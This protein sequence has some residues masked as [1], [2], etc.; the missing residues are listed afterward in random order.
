MDKSVS[1]SDLAVEKDSSSSPQEKDQLATWEYA[2]TLGNF[3]LRC[4]API[5]VGVQ[6]EWGSGKTSLINMVESHLHQTNDK[7]DGDRVFTL[8][9]NTW[10]HSLLQTPESTLIS[11]IQ[12]IIDNLI[13]LDP[14]AKENNRRENFKKIMGNLARRATWMGLAAVGGAP[15]VNA[16]KASNEQ[17]ADEEPTKQNMIKELRDHL[18]NLSTSIKGQP[19][20]Y[21]RFVIFIDDLDRLEPPVAVAVLELL[22]NI[23]DIPHT[24]FVLAIDYQVVVKG[25]ASKFGDLNPDNEREFRSFFDKIIQVPFMM[26]MAHYSLEK[27]VADLLARINYFDSALDAEDPENKLLKDLTKVVKSTIG[28][29]PRSLKRLTNSLAL[30][31]LQRQKELDDKK[32]QLLFCLICFQIGFPNVFEILL[33]RPYFPDWTDEMAERF[34]RSKGKN[35][36]PKNFEDEIDAVSKGSE[37]FDAED[38][39]KA[40]QRALFRVI[41]GMDWQKTRVSETAEVLQ[42]IYEKFIKDN[43]DNKD[44]KD[45]EELMKEVLR[46]AGTTSVISWDTTAS[47]E[48][49]EQENGE[50]KIKYW[51]EFYEKVQGTPFSTGKAMRTAGHTSGWFGRKDQ[52][53][54]GRI[55]WAAELS[56]TN[57]LY[58]SGK[59]Q[60]AR[61]F[62]EFLGKQ[63]RM[64]SGS[65]DTEQDLKDNANSTH[66]LK[67]Y[68]KGLEKRLK[69][70]E[71]VKAQKTAF[72]FLENELKKLRKRVLKHWEKFS[73][74]N[75]SSE[76]RTENVADDEEESNSA[77]LAS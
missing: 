33:R 49:P 3:I 18:K 64:N 29:N 16:Y 8:Q 20:E 73:E 28:R 6:G 2:Q 70:Y 46:L 43:K 30:I 10:E 14:K 35:P 61:D 59:G 44:N 13:E 21:D 65:F 42:E 12:D 62:L 72:D 24:I 58:L 34:V 55:W 1:V 53:M 40:W 60:T 77:N 37:F 25:L 69:L 36:N 22:K 4:E 56:S 26:P 23:F 66:K 54:G 19:G 38:D 31:N 47:S 75:T 48:E 39:E 50:A 51:Q 76:N 45:G 52:E 17:S 32:K 71:D 63:G 5:T 74:S 67:I 15:A 9:I 27:Y 57:F 41:W 68:P 11:I 7:N